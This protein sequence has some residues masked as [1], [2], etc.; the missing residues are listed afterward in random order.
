[1]S[2]RYVVWKS[3]TGKKGRT[4][5]ESAMPGGEGV[6]VGVRE[7]VESDDG[8]TDVSFDAGSTGNKRINP[9]LLHRS[10]RARS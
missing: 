1:M 8:K 2:V 5:E 6:V 3:N 7:V 9:V 4:Q 10:C